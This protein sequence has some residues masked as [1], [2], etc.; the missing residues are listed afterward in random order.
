MERMTTLTVA[1]RGW[2]HTEWVGVFYPDDLPEEWRLTYYAN[3]FS[4]VLIP[5]G[6]WLAADAESCA[7]WADDVAESFR[8]YL[9]LPEEMDAGEILD[10]L[11]ACCVLLGDNLGGVLVWRECSQ[12]A[13]ADLH[14]QLGNITMLFQAVDTSAYFA[15]EQE[16]ILF[17]L[18]PPVGDRPGELAAVLAPEGCLDLRRLRNLMLAITS[19]DER[20]NS[21]LLFLTGS[22]PEITQL[23][24]AHT[25]AGML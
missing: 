6:E 25:L 22:P 23:Q 21:V 11:K 10:R 12:E 3:E 19:N 2:N 5:A 24:E 14:R 7:D 15:I 8:F 17:L 16:E 20:K 18:A 13:Q 1:S 4:A 9:E